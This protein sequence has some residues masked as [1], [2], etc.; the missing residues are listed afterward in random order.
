MI[1]EQIMRNQSSVVHKVFEKVAVNFPENVAV[2]FDGVD[3]TYRELN[4]RANYLAQHL[5][6]NGVVK[7]EVVGIAM[8]HSVE[9]VVSML[10]ILKCGA[11]YLPIDDNNPGA[12]NQKYLELAKVKVL[13]VKDSISRE[14]A[15][16]IKVVS[17][18]NIP[19]FDMSLDSFVSVDSDKNDGAYIMFTS[20]STGDPKGVLVP[21]RAI[22][23][24]VIDANYLEVKQEDRIL[25]LAPPSFDA[26]TLEFWGAL[27]N[28]AILVPYSSDSLDPNTLKSDIENNRITILW[29]TAALFHLIT[30]KFIEVI[31]PLR[32]LLAGGDVLNPKY[33]NRVL[34]TIPGITLIN[35]YGPTENTTFTCC[36]V[37]TA[38]NK[39]ENNVPI[40]K[41]ISGTDIHIL[42]E[43]L[44]PVGKGEV[45]ELYA[46]GLGVALGYINSSDKDNS[47]FTNEEIAE[48]IIY[49]TGDLVSENSQGEI[50]FV[51]RRDNQ[52]KIRGF[53]VSLEEVKT[54]IVEMD[55]VSDALVTTKKFDSGD[56][57]LVAYVQLKKGSDVSVKKL[58]EELSTIVPDYMIPDKFIFNDELPINEN[59][60]IDKKKILSTTQ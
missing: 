46:S 6:N 9:L 37:M 59:G 58:K 29:L 56:Q 33:V 27:L 21:H 53:R 23:R 55:C 54:S 35:G 48:G 12:R 49:R 15:N 4:S 18:S 7:G 41:A 34:E 11:V 20:G 52:V 28:G 38:E 22:I 39:P 17:N 43:N 57:L 51:G 42:D 8:T 24:L 16:K 31:K 2:K 19:I 36:H 14:Y 50:K 13:V 30:D 1:K 10:A 44:Q 3:V 25:Q 60:K 40:G 32:V 45:G 26:S 47:F 5:Q